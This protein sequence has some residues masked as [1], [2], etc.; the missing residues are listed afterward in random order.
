MMLFS[1]FHND[2]NK[3]ALL[4]VFLFITLQLYP[5]LDGVVEKIVVS[6]FSKIKEQSGEHIIQAE[7][8]ERI[9]GIK[10]NLEQAKVNLSNEVE[11][12]SM[13]ENELLKVLQGTSALKPELLNKKYDEAE[14][15]VAQRKIS[16]ESLERELANS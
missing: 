13:L 1:H 3:F 7:F 4:F 5:K 15:D 8:D 2:P 6:I 10:L 11:V 16:V 14:Y 9:A 12:L